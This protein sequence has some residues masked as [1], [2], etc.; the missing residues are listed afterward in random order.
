MDRMGP[1]TLDFLQSDTPTKVQ[2][3]LIW[4]LV[5]LS[6]CDTAQENVMN[7]HGSFYSMMRLINLKD[8]NNQ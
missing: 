6:V 2:S 7:A 3:T 5:T 8:N 4:L 1:F